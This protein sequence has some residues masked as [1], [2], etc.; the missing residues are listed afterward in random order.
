M[1]RFRSAPPGI[2][3]ARAI[4][5]RNFRVGKGLI[6]V[7]TF[8]AYA[9]YHASRKPPSIVK[10]VLDPETGSSNPNINAIDSIAAIA[11]AGNAS[12][13]QEIAIARPLSWLFV[14][15]DA[16]NAARL[17]SRAAGWA[18]FNEEGGKSRLGQI[19]VAFL[20]CYAL[21]MFFAG[22]LG[23]RLD[24]RIFLTMGMVGSGTFVCLFG[25]GYWWNIHSLYYF[26]FVQMIAGL[27]QATGWPSV[28]AIV[29]NWCGKSK[30]GLIMGVW[31]AHTSVGN[32]VGSLVGAAVLPF[33]WG[34]SFL[35]PGLLIMVGGVMVYLFLVVDP[36]DVDLPS[37]YDGGG[38]E[39]SSVQGS[40]DEE[41]EDEAGSS[42][43][44]S[45]VSDRD[46]QDPEAQVR[47][48]SSPGRDQ[49]VGFLEA[50]V[51]PGVAPFAFCLFFSKLVA[52]TFLYWLP[53]YVRHTRI[54]GVVLSDTTAANLSI[55]FDIGGVFGGVLA[56]HLSDK[57]NARAITA[58][59]FTYCAIP[60]LFFYHEFGA[61]S[62][63]LNAGLM[64]AL[65][66]LVNGPYA[67]ITTAVSADLGTHSSLSGDA[68]ALSTVTAIIDGCGS[69]GAAVGPLLTGYISEQG[70]DNVFLMLMASAFMAG[71]L[72][73]RL[74]V[75]EAAEKIRGLREAGKDSSSRASSSGDLSQP[76][77]NGKG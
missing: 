42:S 63:P 24:L 59:T 2:R 64:L 65:G 49:P 4:A 55:L 70:W 67:L 52:Y 38:G 48:N 25:L 41:E 1:D 14:P 50:W 71:L 31:N 29:G 69:A 21:G 3:V 12:A 60:A 39:S 22:H 30:R 37:P 28:V 19:D 18:P 20:A 40:S 35:L 9:C 43:S 75:N 46:D 54:A 8:I 10:S 72:L 53:F 51:I 61:I 66:M 36:R 56:G 62:M 32:I 68:R 77:I 13:V 26:L 74:V 5:G 58:A 34:W 23:D 44:S 73:S 7:I 45:L 11:V 76:F 47:K 16:S 15:R 27:F 6:L 57:L 33:G 17:Q